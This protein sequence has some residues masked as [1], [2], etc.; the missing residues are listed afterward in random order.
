MIQNADD[1]GATEVSFLYD[2]RCY[3][4]NALENPELSKFQGPALYCHN[5]AT[6]KEEDWE[7]IQNLMRSNK[8][9]DPLKVGR[10]GI[11]FNSVYHITGEWVN[12]TALRINF[13]KVTCSYRN[14]YRGYGEA[15]TLVNMV[16]FFTN[17]PFSLFLTKN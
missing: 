3:G 14:S 13:I 9:D 17:Y 11:G 6:F 15:V 10:F 4:T 16:V 2:N 5:D 8:K 1:A 12:K 7:G